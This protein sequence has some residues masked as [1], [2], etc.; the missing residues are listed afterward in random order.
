MNNY[1]LIFNLLS[2]SNKDKNNINKFM[3]I[4]I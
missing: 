3:L 4:Q 2:I 1:N